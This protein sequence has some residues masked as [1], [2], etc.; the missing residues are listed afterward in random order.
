[1]FIRTI[2]KQPMFKLTALTLCGG[3]LAAVQTRAAEATVDSV[4]TKHIQAIG[5]E[6]ALKKV[7]SRV[8][9]FK[10]DSQAIGNSEGKIFAKA[11]NKQRSE[12]DI[13]NAGALN[14]GFDGTV[15]WA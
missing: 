4:V 1:M 12:I 2:M 15:A 14:E 8:M 6:A 10:L 3:L 7:N 5:G 11:P 9:A 13:A